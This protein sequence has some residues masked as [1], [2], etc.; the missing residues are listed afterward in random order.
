[1]DTIT[2]VF[3]DELTEGSAA[4][5]L[6]SARSDASFDNHGNHHFHETLAC[7]DGSVIPYEPQQQRQDIS[8]VLAASL[9]ND[10]IREYPNG[11]PFLARVNFTKVVTHD[12]YELGDLPSPLQTRCE[13]STEGHQ[14]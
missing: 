14:R 3:D 12:T 10:P 5:G 9:E 7:S 2:F 11:L 4:R 1:M 8:T 6:F 13:Q